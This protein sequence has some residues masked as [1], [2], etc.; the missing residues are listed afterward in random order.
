MKQIG[1]NNGEMSCLFFHLFLMIHG[2]WTSLKMVT[3]S[4]D[5]FCVFLQLGGMGMGM[6]TGYDFGLGAFAPFQ[7]IVNTLHTLHWQPPSKHGGQLP[8]FE[9][10]RVQ[11]HT[12]TLSLSISFLYKNMPPLQNDT[13]RDSYMKWDVVVPGWVV[14]ITKHKW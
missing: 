5:L 11:E 4:L 14:F 8:G 2:A 1:V 12:H 6:G 13:P 9:I 3:S 10:H 7:G